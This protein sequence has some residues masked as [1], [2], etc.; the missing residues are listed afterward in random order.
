MRIII[1]VDQS[2]IR[3]NRKHPELPPL[4]PITVKDYQH[5]RKCH[6]VRVVGDLRL[7]HGMTPLPCGAR[8]WLECDTATAEV[9]IVR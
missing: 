3:R 9:T 7:V 1:H 6:E 5:N 2:A 8:V 4:P